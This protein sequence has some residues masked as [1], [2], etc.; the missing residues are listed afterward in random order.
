MFESTYVMHS[1]SY[2]PCTCNIEEKIIIINNEKQK[3]AFNEPIWR[4]FFFKKMLTRVCVDE[5]Q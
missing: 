5:I 3:F 4:R 2:S 1:Y